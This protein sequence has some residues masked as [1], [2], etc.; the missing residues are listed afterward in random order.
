M[1]KKDI[2][3]CLVFFVSQKERKVS[4]KEIEYKFV[5]FLY[6]IFDDKV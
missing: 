6:H 4:L 5:V 3:H 2:R 1:S